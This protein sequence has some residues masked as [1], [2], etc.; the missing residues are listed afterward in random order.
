MCDAH[1]APRQH[2]QQSV[3]KKI[4]L[5]RHPKVV[6]DA[7]SR[8][9]FAA[10]ARIPIGWISWHSYVTRNGRSYPSWEAF[11]KLE[12]VGAATYLGAGR[13][14]KADAPWPTKKNYAETK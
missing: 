4:K 14:V 2:Q 12:A 6:G 5:I 1:H 8:D 9:R 13:I 10:V 11:K 7:T 3:G